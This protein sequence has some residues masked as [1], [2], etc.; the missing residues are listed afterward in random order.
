MEKVTRLVV[1]C[2]GTGGHLYPGIAVARAFQKANPKVDV[3]FVGTAAGMESRIVPQQGFRFEAVASSGFLGK[4]ILDRI[5]SLGRVSRGLFQAL[6]ILRRASPQMVVGVG[7]YASVPAILAAALLRIPRVILEP[8]V[9]PGL[10]NRTMAPFCSLIIAA[11]EGT[12]RHLGSNRVAVLGVPIRPELVDLRRKTG[13]KDATLLILGGSQGARA[14]NEAVLE[15]LPILKEKG[16][17]LAIIHQ[18][19]K[20]DV[21]TARKAYSDAGLRARV[22]P[23]IEEMAAVYAE[24]D[25][26]IARAGAA[27]VAELAAVGLPS[28]LIP[29]PHAAG[30]QED[31]AR[32]LEAAGGARVILQVDLTAEGLAKAVQSLLGDPTALREMGEAARKLGKPRAAEAIVEACEKLIKENRQ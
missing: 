9:R 25:L 10:A 20:G 5:K 31:N 14:I 30:H 27:T 19:G 18:T 3:L 21:E 1:A 24:A 32:E 12:R 22:E 13:K 6:G 7:G 23:F 26:V 2:G 17:D 15:M 16:R 8:N 11:F 4:G 28:I 29:F